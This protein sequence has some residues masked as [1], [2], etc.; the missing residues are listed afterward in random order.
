MPQLSIVIPTYNRNT[1]LNNSLSRLVDADVA[2]NDVRI[3]IFDNA[4]PVP[5]ASSISSELKA[6]LCEKLKI[7]RNP[8]NVGPCANLLKAVEASDGDWVWILSDDDPPIVGC[9]ES[10]Y[11]KIDEVSSDTT[12]INFAPPG[13]IRTKDKITFGLKEFL[14]L[15]NPIWP[16]TN[17]S[18]SIYRR[19]AF[20]SRLD[21]AYRANFSLYP[22]WGP[23]LLGLNDG[24]SVMH[25]KETIIEFT[26]NAGFSWSRMEL[27]LGVATLA[28]L[29]LKWENKKLLYRHL[30]ST[31][32]GP[33]AFASLLEKC[34]TEP[35]ERCVLM[36]QFMQRRFAD[37]PV[38]AS[39]LSL[40]MMIY[41][42]LR[43]LRT[44]RRVGDKAPSL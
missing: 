44:W 31:T 1:A 9:L 37:Q 38:S 41:V 42:V 13:I 19:S 10:I 16:Y 29:P 24:G 40:L 26:E 27:D 4:S 3:F 14:E 35:A 11:A 23:L 15:A 8:Y 5:V 34:S 18:T 6:T 21:P 33:R 2:A 30:R 22:H 28:E 43:S 36:N 12:L 25:A 20:V 7:V 32:P 17:I 39:V